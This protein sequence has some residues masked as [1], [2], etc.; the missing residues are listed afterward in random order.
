MF[1]IIDKSLSELLKKTANQKKVWFLSYI[2]S[3]KRIFP[4]RRANGIAPT[5]WFSPSC[6]QQSSKQLVIQMEYFKQNTHRS[7]RSLSL[8]ARWNLPVC[9]LVVGVAQWRALLM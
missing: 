4:R 1:E 2:D 8:A 7:S 9:S 5:V 6:K 3:K